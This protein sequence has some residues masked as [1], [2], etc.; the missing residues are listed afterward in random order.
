MADGIDTGS[1]P[2]WKRKTLEQM[3]ESEWE[4][5]CDGCGRCC[6]VKLEDEDTGD[7]LYT[8]VACTLFN[9]ETCRCRDYVN[10]QKRVP[11]CIRL[12]P[13]E[14]RTLPWLPQTCAY[15]LL[16]RNRDLPDWHPLVS[17]NGASVRDAGVSVY[18]HVAGTEDEYS[19]TELMDRIVTWPAEDMA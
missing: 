17:G 4:S 11:D 13:R 8:D 18:G 14:V 7:I 6:L 5:L 1:V 3:T 12:T 9:P 19:E 2:F 10:R 16:A 15:F